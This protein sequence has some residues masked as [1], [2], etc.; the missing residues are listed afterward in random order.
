MGAD[1]HE[2]SAKFIR[3][4]ANG[5]G[6]ISL[7]DDFRFDPDVTHRSRG[8]NQILQVRETPLM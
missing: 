6:D 7:F 4:S 8:W 3:L 2:I 1:A 5:R